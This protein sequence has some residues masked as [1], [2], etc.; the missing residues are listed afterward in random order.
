MAGAA[1]PAL[2]PYI[3]RVYAPHFLPIKS[4]IIARLCYYTH[5]DKPLTNAEKDKQFDQWAQAIE[6]KKAIEEMIL[7]IFGKYQQEDK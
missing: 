2:S 5:M 7:S 1:A 4:C 3:A 6:D